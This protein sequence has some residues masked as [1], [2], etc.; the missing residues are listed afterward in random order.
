M[1]K[2]NGREYQIKPFADLKGADLRGADLEGAN[3]KGADL[4]KADLMKIALVLA[5]ICGA[6]FWLL[7]LWFLTLT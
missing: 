4:E 7:G 5:T 3:L 6:I 2:I 1:M